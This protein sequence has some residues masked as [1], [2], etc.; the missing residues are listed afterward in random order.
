[1]FR[2][3]ITQGNRVKCTDLFLIP[4][5]NNL[6]AEGSP[7]QNAEHTNRSTNMMPSPVV[8]NVPDFMFHRKGTPTHTASQLILNIF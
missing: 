3:P 5:L 2:H 8:H 4:F 1:M 7:C 6:V